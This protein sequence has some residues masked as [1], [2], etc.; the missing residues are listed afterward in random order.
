MGGLKPTVDDAT[1]DTK[2]KEMN[3]MHT[4]CNRCGTAYDTIGWPRKCPNAE[5]GHLQFNNPTPIGVMLQ[6]VTD[7]ERTGIVTPIRGHAP[8]IGR[9]AGTGGFQEAADRSSEHA[10]CREY[11]EE[12]H[13]PEPSPADVKLLISRACGPMTPVGKRQVLIFGVNQRIEHIDLYKDF[14]PDHETLAIEFSWSPR[15]LAFP[16]HTLALALYFEQYQGV[17]AP[18][19]HVDQPQTGDVV[20]NH[21]IYDVPYDQP[22]LDDGIWS[23]LMS[24]HEMPIGIVRDGH[25]WKRVD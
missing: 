5:C 16:T 12:L 8:M 14:V 6:Q 17:S 13:L 3:E 19:A 9:P 11:G 1:R 25:Q 21:Q 23:V 7:G 22:L 24:E 18:K 2:G 20:G 4:C 15:V 10:G